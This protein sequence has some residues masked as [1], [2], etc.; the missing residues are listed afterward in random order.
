LQAIFNKNK[1]QNFSNQEITFK[2]PL[3]SLIANQNIEQELNNSFF[4][5]T[6][7][8]RLIKHILILFGVIP[9][10]PLKKINQ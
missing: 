3:Q 4:I 9:Q 1:K 10:T 8:I 6:K 7:I 2:N 5:S